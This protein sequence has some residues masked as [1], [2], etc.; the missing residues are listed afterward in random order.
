[1]HAE[2]EPRPERRRDAEAGFSLIE[3]LIAALLLAIIVAGI[4]P[5]FSRA[6]LN[7]VQ[8]NDSSQMTNATIVG[9]ESLFGLQFNNQ[10]L[11]LPAG[12]DE[13]ERVDQYSL[14]DNTWAPTIDESG[15]DR[16]QYER[17]VRVQQFNFGDIQ[18]DGRLD[19]PLPGGTDPTNVHLKLIEI[20][21]D[22]RRAAG[23]AP[24]RVRTIQSY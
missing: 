19:T 1:M 3:G 24:Y 21:V 2:V 13:L 14:L 15:P 20:T 4:L 8:G 22:Q 11:E 17:T 7:N 12:G 6:M 18:L 23:A 5:L 16:W 9:F 10:D